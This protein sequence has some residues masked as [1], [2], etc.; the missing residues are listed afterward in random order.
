METGTNDRFTTSDLLY[1]FLSR[2]TGI[3]EAPIR[4][5]TVKIVVTPMGDYTEVVF[6]LWLP[7]PAR[8]KQRRITK[9][10]I[11]LE[12][13]HTTPRELPPHC[14]HPS[15]SEVYPGIFMELPGAADGTGPMLGEMF[16]D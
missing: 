2:L 5:S 6:S 1:D 14:E 9:G 16:E 3:D 7:D 15:A 10:H 13:R 12:T 11:L 8:N 4:E